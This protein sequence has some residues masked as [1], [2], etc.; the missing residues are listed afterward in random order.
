[1]TKRSMVTL[2]FLFALGS[3]DVL[4]DE[5]WVADVFTDHAVLQQGVA[6]RNRTPEPL[7]S[8]G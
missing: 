6:L 5:L 2:V 1:M 7:G 3:A 4:A 8:S